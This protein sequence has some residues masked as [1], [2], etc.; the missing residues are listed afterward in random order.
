M[1]SSGFTLP[2]TTACGFARFEIGA[3]VRVI[4]SILQQEG[5]F[6]VVTERYRFSDDERGLYTHRYV[7]CFLD[8]TEGV[9]FTSEL[10]RSPSNPR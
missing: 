6:G 8:G 5:R 9:F 2:R 1:I 4:A 10:V 3:R 7:V